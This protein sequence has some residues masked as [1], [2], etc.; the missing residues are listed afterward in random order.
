M[1]RNRIKP[2]AMVRVG[3]VFLILASL[4]K[5]FLHRGPYRAEG[6]ADGV[7]GFLFGVSIG[8][9]LLGLYLHSRHHSTGGNRPCA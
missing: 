7:T 6:L 3:L 8:A 2:N 1:F 4:A 9:M 5:W